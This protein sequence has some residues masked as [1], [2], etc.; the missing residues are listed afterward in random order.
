[1]VAVSVGRRAALSKNTRAGTPTRIEAHITKDVDRA[2]FPERSDTD[3]WNAS[4]CNQA[5]RSRNTYTQEPIKRAETSEMK[6][7][8]LARSACMQS[9]TDYKSIYMDVYIKHSSSY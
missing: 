8:K 9:F 4:V 6:K 2:M 3:S 7:V 5:T 1:M